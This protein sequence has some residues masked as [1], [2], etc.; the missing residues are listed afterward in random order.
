MRVKFETQI[1][2]LT[3]TIETL[4]KQVLVLK[5]NIIA[6]EEDLQKKKDVEAQ[7]DEALKRE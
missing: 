4:E 3:I 1:N 2:S 7:L 5:S 6:L